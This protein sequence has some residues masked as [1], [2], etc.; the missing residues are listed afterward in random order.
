[1]AYIGTLA[2]F[3]ALSFALTGQLVLA[4]AP[5]WRILASLACCGLLVFVLSAP[6]LGWWPWSAL[7]WLLSLICVLAAGLAL[8]PDVP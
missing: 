5:T 4:D 6:A 3:L 2:V 1:M 8:L 7:T